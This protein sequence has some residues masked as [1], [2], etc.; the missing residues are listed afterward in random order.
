HQHG[1]FEPGLRGQFRN[2]AGLDKTGFVV[3]IAKALEALLVVNL[4]RDRARLAEHGAAG[5][6]IRIRMLRLA[7]VEEAQAE[8]IDRDAVRVVVAALGVATAVL[9]LR[10]LA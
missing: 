5:L 3:R 7:F 8:S 4:M 1:S 10:G 6:G 2:G 9:V